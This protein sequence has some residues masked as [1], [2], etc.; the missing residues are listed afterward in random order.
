M[1]SKP[2][3]SVLLPAVLCCLPLRAERRFVSSAQELNAVLSELA[4]GDELVW[5]DG[6][7]DAQKVK[8]SASGAEGRPIV[9]RAEHPGAVEFTGASSIS[10]DG[11]W[12]VAEGFAFRRLD[13]SV[14]NTPLVFAKGSTNC[15]IS[16]CLIDGRGSAESSVDS[17]WV[18]LYGQDHEVSHCS[19][20]DKR[21]M[22]ALL[23][24]WMEKDVVPAHR[25]EGNHFTRP[26]T[27]LDERGRPRNGQEGIRIG[28]SPFW[29]QDG[30]CVIR[31]NYF[32]HCDGEK[33]ETI[34]VKCCANTVEGNALENSA[35]T[36]TLR[37]AH[38]CTVR[39]NVIVSDGDK[40]HGGI[41]IG[42]EGHLVEGNTLVGIRGRV[43]KAP[44]S[45][46]NGEPNAP[47]NGY[48]PV[49]GLMLR[50]NVMIGCAEGIVQGAARRETMT[51][52]PEGVVLQGN[53]QLDKD[54]RRTAAAL[55]KLE[56]IKSH[57]GV[58]W[59]YE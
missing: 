22:G 1:L 53:I 30:N 18:S 35:G 17:K 4:P 52:K 38:R 7:Y 59:Q 45:V 55:K 8:L 31:G 25:I 2:L 15:R 40:E 54:A 48:V 14:K 56:Q 3:L 20:L 26:F 23:V 19:F 47:D 34:S 21:N 28:T 49:R 24:V 44:I 32:Y 43:Y 12:L 10:L 36:V 27:I 13:N 16:D 39:D 29:K 11:S 46:M 37:H 5:R 58:R 51:V 57:A 6:S 33:A 41:R 9:L 42:G 50:D